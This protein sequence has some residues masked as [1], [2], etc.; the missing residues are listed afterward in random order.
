[1]GAGVQDSGGFQLIGP[2]IVALVLLEI[3]R[4]D[5]HRAPE[6]ARDGVTRAMAVTG[7]LEY[8]AELSWLGVRVEAELAERAILK[9][10]E[11]RSRRLL[12]TIVATGLAVIGLVPK[13]VEVRFK[14]ADDAGSS[15]RKTTHRPAGAVTPGLRE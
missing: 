15:P 14:A 5:L 3:R 7:D 2:A 12:V 8:T 13:G 6:R 9:P 10:R 11:C 1:V 4:G